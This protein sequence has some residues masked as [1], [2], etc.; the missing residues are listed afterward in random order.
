M[1]ITHVSVT[2]VINLY[3]YTFN[4]PKSTHMYY[5]CSITG[6]VVVMLVGVGIMLVGV[7]IML[8]GVG[9]MSV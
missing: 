1:C 4:T 8:V 3:F 9:I 2:H 7:D 5:R 6:H